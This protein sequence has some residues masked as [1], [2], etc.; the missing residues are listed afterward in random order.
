MLEVRRNSYPPTPRLRRGW[1]TTEEAGRVACIT[2]WD[3]N[4][5]RNNCPSSYNHVIADRDRKDCCICSNTHMTAKFGR[6]PKLWLSGRATG[7]ER[8]INKHRS[9]RN[10]AIV[11]DCDEIADEGV[12]LYPAPLT[13]D[14]SLLDLNERS[15][16][17][18]IANVTTVQVCRLYDGDICTELHVDEP[19][20]AA[21]GWI[22]TAEL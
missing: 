15:D 9:M 2:A 13:D 11:P 20:R 3:C 18:L 19:D 21:P 7:D 16:E 8:I 12:G 1:K 17:S 14:C 10:E 22:H 6:P 4:I 5:L